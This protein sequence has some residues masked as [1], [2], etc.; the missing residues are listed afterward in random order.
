MSHRDA[1]GRPGK[2]GGR[3]GVGAILLLLGLLAWGLQG[4]EAAPSEACRL[5]AAR[6]ASAPEQLDLKALASLG[7]CL[8]GEIAERVGAA[9]Q[10]EAPEAESP[11]PPQ[12]IPPPPEPTPLPPPPPPLPAAPWA[13][14]PVRPYGDWPPSAPWMGT[15]P[16]SPW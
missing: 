9:E 8:T 14:L 13:P 7:I 1:D 4:A 10:A 15:W 11:I 2:V 3:L 12:A 5:L 6:F 16:P